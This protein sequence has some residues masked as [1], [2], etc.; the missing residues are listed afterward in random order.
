[1]FFITVHTI[2]WQLKELPIRKRK[3]II[4]AEMLH[5]ALKFYNRQ[6]YRESL[7]IILDYDVSFCDQLI[8]VVQVS[9]ADARGGGGIGPE[10][11]D[12]L[13]DGIVRG[14]GHA[15]GQGCFLIELIVFDGIFL[16]RLHRDGRNEKIFGGKVC[17]LDDHADGFSKADLQQVE[18]IADEFHFFF[19]QHE[20][21]F[22]IAEDISIDFGQGVV[23]EAGILGV[24]GNE[25]GEGIEGIEDKVRVYLVFQCFQL[26]LGFGDVELFDPGAAVF[27]FPVE[28]DDLIYIG[29]KA[30]CDDDEEGGADEGA[31]MIGGLV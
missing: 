29:N 7:E 11:D 12:I 4:L 14:Y 22:F 17:D 2:A 28:E 19:Q 1:M 31:I 10:V 13:Y 5:M 27:S 25:E 8:S 6:F 20:V 15:D 9:Q 18:I 21:F 3:A 30:G 23:V 26:G 24:A 16:E